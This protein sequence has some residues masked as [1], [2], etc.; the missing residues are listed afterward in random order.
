VFQHNIIIF[1]N[2][3]SHFLYS[4]WCFIALHLWRTHF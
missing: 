2:T 4:R 1:I 3:R